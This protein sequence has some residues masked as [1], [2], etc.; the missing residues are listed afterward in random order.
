MIAATQAGSITA[1][2]LTA[3]ADLRAAAGAIDV[4]NLAGRIR[5]HSD[6]GSI[7]GTEL[8]GT[9]DAG[10]SAGPTSITIVDDVKR[11]TA[12]TETGPVDL[13]VPMSPTGS[14]PEQV[15]AAPTST[16][17]PPPTPHAPSKPHSEVGDVT[18]RTG[19]HSSPVD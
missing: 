1:P 3:G 15:S 19:T 5:L 2:D 12:A 16:S 10:T 14:T 7:S 9:V 8:R 4:H 11:M 18:V 17:Q 6:A 13:V